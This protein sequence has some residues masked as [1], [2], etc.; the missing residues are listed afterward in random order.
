MF[1]IIIRQNLDVL[2]ICHFGIPKHK[3]SL[4]IKPY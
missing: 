2:D 1:W 4:F 3:S